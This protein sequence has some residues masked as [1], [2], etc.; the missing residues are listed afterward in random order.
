MFSKE[1]INNNQSVLAIACPIEKISPYERDYPLVL[2]NLILGGGA[3]SKLFQEVR[4]KNSLCYSKYEKNEL[5]K[6]SSC[7]IFTSNS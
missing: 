1:V 3:D 6:P 7:F 2:A 4:E 5:E